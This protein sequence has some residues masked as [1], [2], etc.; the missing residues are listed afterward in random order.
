MK[1]ENVEIIK[2]IEYLL[3]DVILNASKAALLLACLLTVA[4]LFDI[5]HYNDFENWRRYFQ[6]L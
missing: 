6:E 3:F 5:Y 4:A 2:R 1:P